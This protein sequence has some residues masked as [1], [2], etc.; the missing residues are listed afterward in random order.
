MGSIA[1]RINPNFVELGK[2]RGHESPEHQYFMRMSVLIP[3]ILIFLTGLFYYLKTAPKLEERFR[4]VFLALASHPGSFLID[5]GHFQYN[6]ISLGLALWSVALLLN[7]RN[8]L[9]AVAFSAA[10][11]YKQMEL[12]H[13]LPIFFYLLAACRKKDTL[14]GQFWALIKIGLATLFTFGLMW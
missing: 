5:Y 9:A 13:A 6:C 7:D 8:V 4:W 14:A 2:S 1:N 10:L 3:D 11:N 12:Y